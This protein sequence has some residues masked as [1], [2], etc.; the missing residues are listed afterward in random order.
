MKAL[1]PLLGSLAIQR[2]VIGAL[3]MREIITRYGRHNIGFLWLFVE[4]AVFTFIITMIWYYTR[5]NRISSIPITALAVTGYSSILLWRNIVSRGKSAVSANNA[6]L[7]H[8]NVKV[9]DVFAARIILEIAGAVTSFIVLSILFNYIGWM[10]PPENMLKIILAL[11]L[12]AWFG[13]SLALIIGSLSERFDVVDRFWSPISYILFV[14]SGFAYL[15]EWLPPA[16]QKFVLLFPMVHGLELLRDG[17]FGSF[18]SAR[19]DLAYTSMCCL[20]LTLLGLLLV[21]TAGRRIDTL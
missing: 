19:Y 9:L 8:R 18:F 12:L 2:R 11:F 4:P 10:K 3:L 21:K 1:L 20:C 5:V 6:V 15:V 13:A 17:Y 7:Y 16:G 14:L